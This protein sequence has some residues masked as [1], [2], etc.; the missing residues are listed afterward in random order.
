MRKPKFAEEQMSF[1]QHQAV[2]EVSVEEVNRKISVP[3]AIFYAWRK[4]YAGVQVGQL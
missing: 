4:K 3:Q 1:A 2:T